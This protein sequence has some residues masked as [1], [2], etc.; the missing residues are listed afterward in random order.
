V[1]KRL[2]LATVIAG[3]LFAMA[4][5]DAQAQDMDPDACERACQ[6]QVGR[7]IDAC[8]GGGDPIECEADCR[9]AG[10]ECIQECRG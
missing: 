6:E 3:G 5:A 8:S 7:C 10:S 4:V 2:R 9:D 1:R